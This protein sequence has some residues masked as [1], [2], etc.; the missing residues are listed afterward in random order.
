MPSTLAWFMMHAVCVE[1]LAQV[2]AVDV[3][4]L[5]AQTKS[6]TLVTCAVA[7][8]QLVLDVTSSLTRSQ[9]LETVGSVLAVWTHLSPVVIPRTHSK[10]VLVFVLESASQ[11]SVGL[12]LEG[13]QLINTTVISK[14]LGAM[15]CSCWCSSTVFVLAY[16]YLCTVSRVCTSVLANLYCK[17]GL[18]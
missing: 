2:G 18:Y 10:T 5:P 16:L 11:T 4:M 7:M 3:I 15:T 13:T 9:Q 6:L 8:K 1:V 14:S 12:V 17:L